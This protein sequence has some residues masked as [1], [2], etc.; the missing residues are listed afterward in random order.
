[1]PNPPFHPAAPLGFRHDLVRWQHL[2]SVQWLAGL[3]AC[4]R[5]AAAPAGQWRL[6]EVGC[7]SLDAFLCG[8]IPG[9]SY[10]DTAELEQEP[11]WNKVPDHT[12]VARLLNHGIRHDTT[13]IL[14][15]R[16]A[17]M[18]ARAAHLMLYAGVNDVRLLDGC[19]AAWCLADLPLSI[20][21]PRPPQAAIDFGAPFPAHPEYLRNTPQARQLLQAPNATLVSIRTWNEYMGKTSGYSYIDSIG[22]IAGARWGHAGKGNDVNSMSDFQHA[23][24][25]MRSAQDITKVW[26]DAGI[27]REQHVAFYCGTGWRASL[28]FFYAW[29]MGW[30]HIS[31][32][33][34]GCYEWSL[35]PA[36]PV[37]CRSR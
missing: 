32:Y 14:Y 19:L 16:Y 34:G 1:M 15:G 31:V 3:L 25:T 8:H 37:I 20:T 5:V 17:V 29:L 30:E 12:L 10:M 23:D 35:D 33:D 13:V 4:S 27:D 9:A 24:G 18:A 36:N 26:S 2:V 28:A 22:D 21:P 7:D 6:L 11:L